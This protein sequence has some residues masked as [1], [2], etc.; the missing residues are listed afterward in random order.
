VVGEP[1]D[2]RSPF[3]AWEA[4]MVIKLEAVSG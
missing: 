2:Y 3:T 4:G 1:G